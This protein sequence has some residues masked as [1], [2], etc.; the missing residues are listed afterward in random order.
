MP[1]GKVNKNWLDLDWDS[2]TG[3][4]AGNVPFDSTSSIREKMIQLAGEGTTREIE[5]VT[6][7]STDISNR[8]IRL[9]FDPLDDEID[10]E[11]IGGS[12]QVYGVDFASFPTNYITWDPTYCSVGLVGLLDPGDQI[13]ITYNRSL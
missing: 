4:N 1:G 11:I 9:T 6:L 7:A 10:M 12:S 3:V 8:Y 5:Y 13:K 2:P